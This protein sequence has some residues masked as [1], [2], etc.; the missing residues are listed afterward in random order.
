MVEQGLFSS[1][2]VVEGHRHFKNAEIAGF[3]DVTGRSDDQP[4]WIVVETLP[5]FVV[6]FFGKRLILVIATP[7][8]KL[9]RGDVDDAFAG[10]FRYL[11]NETDQILIRISETHASPDATFK[12]RCL[13]LIHISEPTRLG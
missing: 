11:M 6:A 7:I 5:D 13:S 8:L 3:L 1:R 2:F 10:T 12:E 9:R 4:K